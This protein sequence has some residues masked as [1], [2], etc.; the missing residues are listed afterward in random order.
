MSTN[1]Y[2]ILLERGFIEQ[3][4]HEQEIRELLGRKSHFLYWI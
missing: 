1:V 4:T 3:T 2:D